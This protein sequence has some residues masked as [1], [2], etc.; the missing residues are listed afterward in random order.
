MAVPATWD[1]VRGRTQKTRFGSGSGW[2]QFG[3]CP[4]LILGHLARFLHLPL[5]LSCCCECHL[6]GSPGAASTGKSCFSE[7]CKSALLNQVQACGWVCG[8][9]LW[10][11]GVC[12]GFKP[13]TSAVLSFSHVQRHRTCKKDSENGQI[14]ITAKQILHILAIY[15]EQKSEM[16]AF[17]DVCLTT[18]WEA[19]V[20]L[21]SSAVNSHTF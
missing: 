10:I 12:R 14:K 8:S 17:D 18:K 9:I 4:C 6:R 15:S 20:P 16:T 21:Q 7:I 3:T 19:L 2:V 13:Q 1:L 11:W 5:P